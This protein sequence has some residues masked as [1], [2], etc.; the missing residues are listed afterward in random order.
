MN[1]MRWLRRCAGLLL[2]SSCAAALAAPAP[3][4]AA[5]FQYFAKQSP[6]EQVLDDFTRAFGLRL[7]LSTQ[8]EGRLNGDYASATPTQF[9]DTMA[10]SY[11]LTWYYHGGVLYVAKASE[12][13][14]RSVRA[15][16]NE[17]GTLKAALVSLGVF[18]SRFGWGEFPERGMVM[19][20]G[21][22]AYVKLVMATIGELGMGPKVGLSAGEELRVFML[23]HARA[24]DRTFTYRDQHVVTPGVASILR[25]LVAGQSSQAAIGTSTATVTTA[26]RSAGDGERK[27]I[28]AKGSATESAESAPGLGQRAVIEVDQRLNAIIVRDTPERINAY[29]ELI[30][31]LDV[32]TPLIEIEAIIV[33]INSDQTDKLGFNWNARGSKGAL[34]FG[35]TASAVATLTL[36]KGDPAGTAGYFLAQVDALA[37]K[38]QARVL[39]RPSVLTG[40]N[41]VAVLDLSQ[42]LYMSVVGERV[43]DVVPV[44][45]GTLLKVTPR[46]IEQGGQRMVQLVVDI[47]DGSVAGQ[48]KTSPTVVQSNISTQAVVRENDSLLIGGYTRESDT[49]ATDS[50]PL[51]GSVPLIG[52]LFRH[53]SQAR[54]RQHRVFLIRPRIVDNPATLPYAPD[55]PVLPATLA[56]PLAGDDAS[57]ATA[58][59]PA[60]VTEPI[61]AP[62]PL[63]EA[64]APAPSTM[65]AALQ[66]PGRTATDAASAAERAAVLAQLEEWVHAWAARDVKRY[67]VCYSEHFQPAGS[68]SRST[69]EA[70]RRRRVGGKGSIRIDVTEPEVLLQ[71]DTARVTF[72]QQYTAGKVFERTRKTLVFNKQPDG[73]R[74]QQEMTGPP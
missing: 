19:L 2:L 6:L 42:T 65:Q 13:L 45:T 71:G 67:L 31:Q 26:R 55:K 25:S 57:G 70:Q 44:A 51:L 34:G 29:G 63:A 59:P 46:V 39:A 35:D 16:K 68:Q 3:W 27:P 24:E 43:A 74:I 8:A 15:G 30:R 49:S 60:A 21:P 62:A 7:E 38:G 48:G 37:S 5:P 53:E 69:W 40:D 32:A 10:A 23:K 36:A 50:L 72:W 4:P 61:A 54:T 52:A 64:V 20:S 18:D 33:D 17:V 41:L 47:E 9:L 1:A 22:P 73:W 56:P 66:A 28:E 11:G 58:S 12:S 14:S